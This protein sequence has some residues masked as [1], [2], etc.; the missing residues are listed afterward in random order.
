[1]SLC[2]PV[3]V[4]QKGLLRPSKT[5][6]YPPFVLIIVQ[7]WVNRTLEPFSS[8]IGR[9]IALAPLANSLLEDKGPVVCSS[10]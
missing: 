8:L 10:H 4:S 7:R 2:A 6:L 9:P 3:K 1:M 5:P